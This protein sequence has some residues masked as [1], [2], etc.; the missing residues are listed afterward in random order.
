VPLKIGQFNFLLG[1]EIAGSQRG[2]LE[3]ME[4][5]L[6]QSCFLWRRGAVSWSASMASALPAL[7]DVTIIIV[8]RWQWTGR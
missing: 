2:F 8:L 4:R 1:R 5:L 3:D 6:G 7:R